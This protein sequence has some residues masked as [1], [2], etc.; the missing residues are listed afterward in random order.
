MSSG[1][2][3]LRSGFLF[4]KPTATPAI[5]PAKPKVTHETSSK[6]AI[7]L[8]GFG[9]LK[10]EDERINHATINRNIDI[11]LM[12]GGPNHCGG[13]LVF[14]HLQLQQNEMAGNIGSCIMYLIT[15]IFC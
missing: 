6:P 4:N 1:T 15:L 12:P 10:D 5:T 14:T 3:F 13:Y 8:E 11:D 9:K 2:T 7:S